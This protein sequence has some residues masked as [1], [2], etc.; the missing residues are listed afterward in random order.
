MTI[1]LYNRPTSTCSQ[2]VRICLAEKNLEFTDIRVDNK[3]NQNLS[4]EYLR[5]NPNGVVP[6][7]IHDGN[8]IIDSSVIC[9]YL[10]EVFPNPRLSPEHPVERAH[11]RAWMRFAEEV[12]A[13]AIRVPSFHMIIAQ[14][15]SG[16]DEKTFREKEADVR[17]LRKHFYRR[18][19][20]RGF[21][22]EDVSAALEELDLTLSR[23]ARA[24]ATGP[25]VMGKDFT[26]ADILLIPTVDRMNDLGLA[27][28]WQERYPCISSWYGSV[29]QRQSFKK[30]YIAGSRLSENAKKIRQL[31]VPLP[32]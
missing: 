2:K 20:T 8:V 32:C 17:P 19:G 23:M 26:L 25:W 10:D 4:P 9:E 14:R 18:M 28:M 30:T 5:L 22:N 31:Q 16:L 6:T 12:P 11:M 15:F 24:L 29:Q 3:T 13:T 27:R 7:M 21:S 1:E